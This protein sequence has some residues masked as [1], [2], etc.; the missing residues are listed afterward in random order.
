M[1]TP[2]EILNA[3]E[4]S[5]DANPSP[6]LVLIREDIA[7]V[8]AA[9]AATRPVMGITANGD[10]YVEGGDPNEHWNQIEVLRGLLAKE[11][12]LLGLNAAQTKSTKGKK[13]T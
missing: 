1:A 11:R 5:R 4:R 8:S 3:Y 6:R 2:E 10:R 13:A 12:D 7:R 9:A